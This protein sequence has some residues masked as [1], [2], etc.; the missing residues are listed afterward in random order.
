MNPATIN[1]LDLPSVPLSARRQLPE[2]PAVYFVLDGM[3]VLYIG[4]SVNLAQRWVGH[5]RLKQAQ[6]VASYPRIAWMELGDAS[7]LDE[8]ER[9]LIQ[10]FE[11]RLNGEV[12]PKPLRATNSKRVLVTLPDTVAAD[13]ESWAEYQ[14]RPTANL[15]SFLIELG[16]R[17]AKAS[18]EFKTLKGNK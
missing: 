17:Q 7:L 6:K 12:I 1:P 2:C 9:A 18:G 16:L 10:H 15:A 3:E 14:G 8:I 11:P 13:L 5:H 4:K